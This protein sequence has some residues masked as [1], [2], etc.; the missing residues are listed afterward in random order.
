MSPGPRGGPRHRGPTPAAR[1]ERKAESARLW[2]PGA[3][4]AHPAEPLL[5]AGRSLAATTHLDRTCNVI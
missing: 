1:E 2:V 4:G 3:Y 5:G